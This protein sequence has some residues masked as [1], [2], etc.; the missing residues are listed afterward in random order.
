MCSIAGFLSSKKLNKE[1]AK[2]LASAL[3]YYG[4]ERGMQSAGVFVDGKTYKKAV[5]PE[6]FVQ[7]HKFLNMFKH[8]VTTCLLHTRQPTCGGRGDDQAQPFNSGK[9]TTIHN[10]WFTN[11]KELKETWSIKKSSGVDS[12]LITSFIDTY[13]IRALPSFLETAS[14]ASAIAAHHKGTIYL[15]RDGNPICYTIV[16]TGKDSLLVFASTP[17]ILLDALKFIFLVPETI[18]V[19][20][21]P[22]ET[23]F[24]V[25]AYGVKE[26]AKMMPSFEDSKWLKYIDEPKD[27]LFDDQGAVEDRL[28]YD[29]VIDPDGTPWDA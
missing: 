24:S 29:N 28:I 25:N 10:G 16:T 5:T 2:N 4:S 13:G 17:N 6:A 9:T 15:M 26:L 3:L 1:T 22:K 7:E 12:E 20:S 23:L 27:D 19:I 18:N 8:D 14:G 11:I 21:L